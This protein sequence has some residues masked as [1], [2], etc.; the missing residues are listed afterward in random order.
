[1]QKILNILIV[2]DEFHA[3]KLLAEY[4]S[5]LSFLNLVKACPNVFEAINIMQSTPV[6]ILILDIQM[7][8][9]TGIEFARSLSKS[10]VIIFSTAYSEYAVESYEL[11]VADY[12]LK[13]IEFPRFLQ[14]INKAT[15]RIETKHPENNIVHDIMTKSPIED[16]FFIVKD[17]AKIHKI[18]YSD[19]L[20]IEGQREYVTFHTLKQKITA[21]YVLKTLEEILPSSLFIRIHKSFIVS[22]KHIELIEGNRLKLSGNNLPIGGNYKDILL[23]LLNLRR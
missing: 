5:K 13:P 11:E 18:Q 16:D 9:M 12:L 2:D 6:D 4:V 3:R 8:D 17:G 23:K 7:P 10:P 22:I 21:L 15:S 14:A 19:L 20:Y 1:M